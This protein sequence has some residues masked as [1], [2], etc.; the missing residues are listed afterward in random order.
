MTVR[1]GRDGPGFL[2]DLDRAAPETLGRQLQEQLRA[3][4]R[5]GRLRPG[6]RLPS[7]RRLAQQLGISRG[8]VV[9]AYEQL[10]AEGYLAAEKGAGTR[11]AA[12]VTAARRRPLPRPGGA[13]PGG[14]APDPV[15]F[16]YGIPDLASFPMGDWTWALAEAARTVP[17]AHLGDDADAGSPWLREVVTSYHRRL[18]A[19]CAAP[20][21][22]V[23]VGGFRHG[24]TVV[25]ATLARRGITHLALEDPG[26]REHDRIA[27]RAGLGVVP[28][29]VDDHGLD[30][31]RLRAS[32]ARAV[33]VTPAHQCPTGALL[34]P[35]RRREL[36]AWAE[37][38]DGLI[39]EDDYDAE[40]RYDRRPVGS[41]QGLA[42][43]R[44]V[45]LGSVSKT[46]APAI[47]IGWV[48]APPE[49]VPAVLEEKRLTSRGVPVLDQLALARLVESGR[50]DR[51]LRRMRTLYAARRDALAE[52][53]GGALPGLPLTG[54]AA[55]C[56]ALLRLP[57]GTREAAVVAAARRR[58]VVVRGLGDY[59]VPA[60]RPG[61]R[62]PGPL[63]PALVLGF[64]NVNES[65]IRRGVRAL[66]EAL[67][68]TRAGDPAGAAGPGPAGGG[69]GAPPVRQ[70]Y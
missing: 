4:V 14:G 6:E 54:L 62:P 55:G 17:A 48:L 37:E 47:K 35:E 39:L 63:G 65:R 18:R 53:L 60:G 43:D 45:A 67:A 15:E 50:F 56:H 9:G 21:D 29:P 24:L 19:G 70:V 44:V 1:W 38:V 25:V 68:E 10:G 57:P 33:L 42:P 52:A 8:L 64:G 7:S 26:P 59:L 2:M 66:A 69:T 23:V 61:D 41:L 30:V 40:F 27:L 46:L 5:S 13:R 28:V 31:A 12:S 36:V 32:P 34:S 3:A 20:A 11:V 16:A 22:A 51:H 49:Y 58:S